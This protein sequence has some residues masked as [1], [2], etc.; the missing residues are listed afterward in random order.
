MSICEAIVT[1]RGGARCGFS[2]LPSPSVPELAREFGLPDDEVCYKEI[3]A[4]DARRLVRSMLHRDL[5]YN[6]ELM[7]L[8]QAQQFADQ[9]LA[10]F[11]S[12]ARYY[13]NG[14]WHLPGAGLTD[15]SS[16][17]RSGIR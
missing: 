12:G 2:S 9:F 10:Y 8:A 14:T 17:E 5:A 16:L 7:P 1:A 4:D 11:G 6:F 3:N 15:R 13:T